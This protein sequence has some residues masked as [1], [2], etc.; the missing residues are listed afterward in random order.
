MALAAEEPGRATAPAAALPLDTTVGHLLRRAQQVHTWLW[1]QELN[2]DL[3]GPQYALLSALT[4]Q[5]V[6]DQRSAGRL[7]S[8]DKS[9]AAD[10]VARLQRNGWLGR[11]RDPSDGRRNLLSLTAP[12]RAALQQ[13]TPRVAGIQ[14]QLLEPL[15]PADREWF[16]QTLALVAYEG[17]PPT[18]PLEPGGSRALPLP[19]TPGHLIRRS[20]QLHGAYWA[21]RV[22]STL[23]PS[24][25]GMLSA[26]AWNEPIDQGT[27]GDLASLDKSSTADIIARLTRRGLVASTPDERDRR[28]KLLVLTPEA[29]AVLDEVTPAVAVVQ[30]DLTA[31]LKEQE[32]RRLVEL[33]HVVAYR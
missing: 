16:T 24:Q 27:A 11:D 26:L 4:E 8:L 23:T 33:L 32:A 3:T 5:D 9:T 15:A 20:E 25:Y 17:K 1:G 22:G 2:G 10:V 18:A 19:T 28:R 6:V 29:R 14:R 13:I 7:A 31:P 30:Q 12:A 21:R